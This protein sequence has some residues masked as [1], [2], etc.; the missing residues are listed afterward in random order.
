ML[1]N[2]GVTAEWDS[3]KFYLFPY[4]TVST[5]LNCTLQMEPLFKKYIHKVLLCNTTN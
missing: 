2:E 4:K 3:L 5:I 1:P